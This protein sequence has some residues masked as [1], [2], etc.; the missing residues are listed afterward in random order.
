MQTMQVPMTVQTSSGQQIIM[1]QVQVQ[2]PQFAQPQFAQMM[3]G[4]QLQPVQIRVFMK[5]K[6][7]VKP[8]L[9]PDFRTQMPYF[10][11]TPVLPGFS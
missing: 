1:Q 8:L 9:K 7:R 4:G 10:S 6:N 2:Q 3:I 5:Q 11:K